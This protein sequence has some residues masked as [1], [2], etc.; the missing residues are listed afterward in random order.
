MDGIT[1]SMDI[2][3]SK[4]GRWWRT[5]KLGMLHSMG[6]QRVEHERETE[7]QKQLEGI[8]LEN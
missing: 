1:D 6:L 5:G 4:V 3:L 2:S 8:V 7:Q